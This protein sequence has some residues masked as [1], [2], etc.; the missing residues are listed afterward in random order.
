[1]KRRRIP[2]MLADVVQATFSSCDG[3]RFDTCEA[4]P[5]CGGELSGYD[6]KKKQ[7]AVL[8]DGE[9]RKVISVFVKRFRCR[10]CEAI[11]LAD[12]PFYPD[13]RVGSPIVDLCVTLGETMHYPRV[14]ATLQEMG[15]IVDRGSVRNYAHMTDVTIPAVDMFGIRVP[16]SVF[17]LSSLAMGRREE[18]GIDSQ[19]MLAACHYPSRR[20]DPVVTLPQE[21]DT[22]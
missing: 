6:V 14:S 16:L 2:P 13:T 17:T 5:A 9:E 10:R 12:Q 3:V 21:P 4:C 22:S 18:C 7:F 19:A 8:M 1:M 20:R 11:C 15:I